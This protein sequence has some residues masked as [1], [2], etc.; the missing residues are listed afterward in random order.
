MVFGCL[1]ELDSKTLL[2]KIPLILVVQHGE[3]KLVLKCKYLASVSEGDVQAPGGETSA[4]LLSHDH[5]GKLCSLV[6]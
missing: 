6:K 4:F 2:R 5:P 1:P 3:I